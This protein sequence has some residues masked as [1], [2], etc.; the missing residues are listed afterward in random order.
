MVIS[1]SKLLVYQRETQEFECIKLHFQHLRRARRDIASL[2]GKLC[3]QRPGWGWGIIFR[4]LLWSIQWCWNVLKLN[5]HQI[6]SKYHRETVGRRCFSQFSD[7]C[8]SD[9]RQAEMELMS[10]YCFLCFKKKFSW[11]SFTCFVAK[12]EC[13]SIAR[14]Y[15]FYDECKHRFPSRSGATCL[16]SAADFIFLVLAFLSCHFVRWHL[17]TDWFGI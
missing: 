11:P 1:H 16:A 4:Q 6:A 3:E 13:S 5:M 14:I 15:G 17:G 7:D 8:L 12:H 9:M 10:W 2:P